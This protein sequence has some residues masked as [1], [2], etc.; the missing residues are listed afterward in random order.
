MWNDLCA[1]RWK[2]QH[3]SESPAMLLAIGYEI[4]IPRQP[5][6]PAQTII[7]PL[8]PEMNLDVDA[9]LS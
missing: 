7:K 5:A 9:M 8:D 2:T 6:M 4:A 1:D 3:F